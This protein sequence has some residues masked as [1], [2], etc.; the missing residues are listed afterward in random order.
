MIPSLLTKY[1]IPLFPLFIKAPAIPAGLQ[2]LA[3]IIFAQGQWSDPL[4][5]GS[6]G[7]T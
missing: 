6:G 4:G 1:R 5:E 7:G 2:F 3:S